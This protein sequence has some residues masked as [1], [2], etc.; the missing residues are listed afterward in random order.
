MHSS[1]AK[2]DSGR[3]KGFTSRMGVQRVLDVVWRTHKVV[4]NNGMSRWRGGVMNV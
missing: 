1:I 4:V 2:D 3:L